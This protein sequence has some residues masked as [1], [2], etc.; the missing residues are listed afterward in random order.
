MRKTQKQAVCCE[1]REAEIVTGMS[2]TTLG[3]TATK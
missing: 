1:G 3:H 2:S